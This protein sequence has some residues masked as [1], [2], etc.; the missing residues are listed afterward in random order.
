MH[1]L[2]RPTTRPLATLLLISLLGLLLAACGEEDAGI[3][4]GGAGSDTPVVS[5]TV[6]TPPAT[7]TPEPPPASPTVTPIQHPTGADDLVLLIDVTGGFMPPQYFITELP[8]L[9]LY[10]DG[11]VVMP[12]PQIAIYPGPAL[13]SL[14]SAKLTEDGIQSILRAA[15][16]AGLLD[17]DAQWQSTMVA[18]AA[19]TYFTVNADG[20]TT[21]VSAY[22]LEFDDLPPNTTDAEREARALLRKFMETATSYFAWM[23]AE[24][25]AEP[26]AQ[27][28][29]ERLQ[30]V[31]QPIDLAFGAPDPSVKPSE[32][33]WP[34]ATPIATMG[35]PYT[36]D[37]S[38]CLVVEGSDLATMLAALKDANQLT[39]WMS[40][41]KPYA[42][43]VRPL[44]PHEA[45]C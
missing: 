7:A 18:D 23:P 22:A 14:T 8:R 44:L 12:G 30:L 27:M 10:G 32:K 9:A 34:L 19:T 2:T 6:T 1:G 42:L 3:G 24:A 29:I 40:D 4:N 25:I 35:V 26:E 43:F 21:S 41:D 5:P 15:K 11:T 36:L 16:D 31:S 13:P 38:R 33:D 20:R 37:Q 28:E 39:Q 17:G 45:G